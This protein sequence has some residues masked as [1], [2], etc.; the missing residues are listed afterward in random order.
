MATPDP[1]T[2][3]KLVWTIMAAVDHANQ[4]GNYS[5]LRDLGAPSFQENNNAAALATIFQ[6]IRTQRLDLSNALVVSPTYDIPPTIIEGGILRA[7]GVFPLRPTAIAFDLLFQPIGGRW[8]LLGISVAPT[9]RPTTPP[10]APAARAP[11]R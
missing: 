1:L 6:S 9:L 11:R 2:T 10:A 3:A 4:T 5:V 8:A 7:R